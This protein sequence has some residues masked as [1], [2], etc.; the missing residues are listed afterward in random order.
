MKKLLW[1]V[2]AGVAGMALA[3]EPFSQ[4]MT[5]EEFKTAGLAKLSPVELARL[6]ALFGKYRGEAEPVAAAQAATDSTGSLRARV[7]EAEA[8]A[9]KAEQ[10][11]AVAREAA[12]AAKTEQRKAEQGFVA[13]A[14]KV[15]VSS[16]TKVE[17]TTTETEID[18]DFTGWEEMT[19]WR[20]TDGS[21]WRV[22]NRPQPYQ[23]TRVKNPKVRI[24]PAAL[25]GFWMEFV[26]LD[27]KVRVRR[28]Q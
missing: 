8:R 27:L 6:D 11:A 17:V 19:A 13:K 25:S 24:Y 1:L 20:M 22:D 23:V 12:Q 9:R 26:D 16:D 2:A 28:L 18:G 5:P 3:A 7:A 4:R 14:K 15:F 21:M 10:E